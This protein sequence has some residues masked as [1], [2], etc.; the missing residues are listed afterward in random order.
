MKVIVLFLGWCGLVLLCWASV[1]VVGAIISVTGVL[2]RRSRAGLG[3]IPQRIPQGNHRYSP[4]IRPA[5]Y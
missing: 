4:Q 5:Q 2:V 1:I 3:K